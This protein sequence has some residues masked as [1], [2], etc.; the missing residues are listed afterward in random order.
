MSVQC[1]LGVSEFGV[2]FGFVLYHG[3][4][5]VKNSEPTVESVLRFWVWILY[6]MN[7][8]VDLYADVLLKFQYSNSKIWRQK[9]TE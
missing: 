9:A 6:L 4:A 2:Q 7:A 5:R 1:A 3:V 8:L